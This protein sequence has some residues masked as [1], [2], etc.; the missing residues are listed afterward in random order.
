M[1]FQ[2]K[3]LVKAIA[4]VL[5]TPLTVYAANEPVC[6]GNFFEQGEEVPDVTPPTVRMITSQ[7]LQLKAGESLVVSLDYTT[8]GDE[9]SLFSCVDQGQLLAETADFSQLKYTAPA[10]IK[11]TQIIR[12]GV[13]ISD[14]LG[15]VGGDSLLLRLVASGAAGNPYIIVGTDDNQ[16]LIYS[17]TG[18]LES[19]IAAIAQQIAAI[20]SD[21]DGVDEIAASDGNNV[22]VYEFNGENSEP[23]IL[24]D[25]V[26]LVKADV[27]GDGVDET[28][29]GSQDAN[30][31]NLDGVS[32]P[33]FESTNQTRRSSTRKQNKVTICHK[34]K[35][36]AIPEPALKGHLGHGDTMGV[37][38]GSTPNPDDPPPVPDPV[39]DPVPNSIYGVNV[40]AG[41]LNADGKAEIVAAMADKGSLVEIY[42]GNQQ[43]IHSFNAFTSNL[44]VLVA[45]GDVT[46]DGQADIITAEPNGTE[47]RIF[48]VNGTQTN[49]FTVSSNI[50]SLVVGMGT[51]EER[52]TP[53]IT[54]ETPDEPQP[55]ES[56]ED[57]SQEI[58]KSIIMPTTG[59]LNTSHNY[60]G[61]T[62][63]DVTIKENVSISNAKLTG[64]NINEGF[65]SN[66]T[67]L[68]GATLEG[69]TVTGDLNNEGTVRDIT[70]VGRKLEGG[71]LGGMI[72]IRANIDSRLGIVM[73]VTLENN[74]RIR[75]GRFKGKIKGNGFAQIEE[76]KIDPN[77]ALSNL[78]I[79]AGCDVSK[80]A[81]LGEE[82]HFANNDLIPEDIDL[83]AAS[84]TDGVIDL[85]TDVVLDAP[86][87]LTQINDLP[88]MQ[89]NN[90]E[91]VQNPDNGQLEVTVEG[92]LLVVKPIHI[93]QS[94]RNRRAQIIGHGQGQVTVITALKREISFQ[95]E[96]A[97]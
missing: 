21:D 5:A 53:P 22:T 13:Q 47:I 12:W 59:E 68:E 96:I 77:T 33:V 3:I 35:D 89:D 29:T 41:D 14:N 48:D 40:A 87:P 27:D 78:I 60:G 65:L 97:E 32:F 90:W 19:D 72:I 4:I 80:D 30:E 46:G 15:Y 23:A 56:P 42:D 61:E 74:T 57:G 39:P 52:V 55:S 16:I 76:A 63:T 93:S 58:I 17:P 20:D 91:L 8:D 31:V 49:S 6:I 10:Y 92:I 36:K 71:V 81:I 69:G 43:L 70:F 50:V 85:N 37:C 66:S 7:L 25:S 51:I 94:K 82:V 38:S 83:T 88:P 1:M 11:E 2:Q 79:G 54:D 67:V 62:L 28:I 24:Q 9:P 64:D 73:N 44:G 84:S 18:D 34:G 86:S 95:L 45:V 75:G 26:F